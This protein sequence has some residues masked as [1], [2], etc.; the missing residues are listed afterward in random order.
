[1]KKRICLSCRYFVAFETVQDR[2]ECRRLP[3]LPI[4]DRRISRGGSV[5]T[6]SYADFPEVEGVSWCG[7]YRKD[8]SPHSS[9]EQAPE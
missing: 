1:M 5:M 6:R 2:G 7:E 4:I 8:E 9:Q 3:P